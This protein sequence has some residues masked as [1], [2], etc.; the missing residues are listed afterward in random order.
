MIWSLVRKILLLPGPVVVY[1]PVII[2]YFTGFNAA[3][4]NELRFWAAII[5]F[6]VGMFF[7]R[8][9]SKLFLTIGDGTPA[10]WEPPQKLVVSGP[11]CYV[12]NP[13]ISGAVLML[14]GE[15]WFFSSFALGVWL[16]VFFIGKT[17]YFVMKEEKE[18]EKRFGE[19]Y[20]KYK[21]NVPR[22]LPRLTPWTGNDE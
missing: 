3:A 20:L 12:R 14:L 17:I 1:I 7:A 9:T 21:A 4:P 18:L 22:W 13:M 16:L 6:I 8:W 11:Y 5:I 10:P 19:D 15:V 2:L